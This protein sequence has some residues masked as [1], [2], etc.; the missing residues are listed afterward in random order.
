MGDQPIYTGSWA[1]EA[2]HFC[3]DIP[4]SDD[5]GGCFDVVRDEEN[6]YFYEKDGTLSIGFR[7]A[8]SP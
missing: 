2:Q 4:E 7:F 3:V 1:I 6:V 5:I 8:G